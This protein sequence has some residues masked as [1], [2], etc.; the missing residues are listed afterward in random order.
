[1]PPE[2]QA[3]DD[4]VKFEKCNVAVTPALW[5]FTITPFYACQKLR[6]NLWHRMRLY[7]IVADAT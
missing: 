4:G 5:P 1:M 3:K 7:T 6:R 2:M